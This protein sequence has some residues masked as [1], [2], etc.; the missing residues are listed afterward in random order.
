[1]PPSSPPLPPPVPPPPVVV[2]GR[3]APRLLPI[4]DDG[5][6]SFIPLCELYEMDLT[7]TAGDST[8]RVEIVGKDAE[9]VF[10]TYHWSEADRA[11]FHTN[12][13]T[14]QLHGPARRLK[15]L[16]CDTRVVILPNCPE[17]F[18]TITLHFRPDKALMDV[19]HDA[20]TM[21]D[22][23][24]AIRTPDL[25]TAEG[26]TLSSTTRTQR[27]VCENTCYYARDNDDGSG[28]ATSSANSPN[29]L[30]KFVV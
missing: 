27:L 26:G 22:E 18:A 20:R 6:L 7:S 29:S 24:G 4:A 13:H 21:H 30:S 17:T 3:S 1:M 19:Y 5:G 14:T 15:S 23:N 12:V 8:L 28:K 2:I 10:S 11:A 9:A 25:V 16:L